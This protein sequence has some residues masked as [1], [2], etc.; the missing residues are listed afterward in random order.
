[1]TPVILLSDGY[2]ANGSEP[3]MIPAFDTLPR[4]II[5]HPQHKNDDRG[6]MPYKRNSDGARPWA[7]PGTAGLEH[8]IGGLEK[9][10]VTGNV[11][12]DPGN[13]EHMVRL[14]SE[15]VARIERDIPEV[16][17]VGD[18]QGGGLL[19]VGW[20]S[21]QGAFT[22]AVQ[23]ARADGLS[24]SRIHLR[25]LNPFPR[26]LGEVLRRFERILVP[27]MNLGQLTML[28]RARYLVDA[29][30]YSKVQGRPF[31]RREIETRVRELL[32]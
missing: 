28:L 20:G 13:H 18:P 9:Q 26:N 25:H 30:V 3:W 16:E 21:T 1:M 31:T 14:R 7:I 12:Y 29:Q 8:R 15:K 22:G 27:E 2:I 4:I 11:S 19:V 17:V 10:D 23:A 24:V 6:F 32:A 5:E